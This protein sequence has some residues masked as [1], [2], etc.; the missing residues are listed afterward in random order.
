MFGFSPTELAVI[1]VIV[2]LIF[3]ARR[4]PEIGKGLGGAIREFKGVRKELSGD[5]EASPKEPNTASKPQSIEA[6]VMDKVLDQVPGVKA[7]REVKDKVE[8][9]KDLLS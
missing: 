4:L 1:A 5:E 3:G 8:K 2:L 6:K 7:V 9:A